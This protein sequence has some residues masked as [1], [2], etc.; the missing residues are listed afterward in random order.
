MDRGPGGGRVSRPVII[1]PS[2]LAAD[3]G[4]LAEQVREATAGGADRFHLDVMDGH[5][6]P[7]FTMGP[8]VVE[9]IRAVTTV[10]LEVHLMVERPELFIEAFIKSGADIV[11]VQVE[12][13][14]QLYRTVHRIVEL[15][16]QAAVALNP[17]TPV[18]ALREI[19]PYVSEIN[20]M[21]VEPGFGG[22]PFIT[23]SPA[24]IARV[25]ALAPEVD[26]QVDGGVDVR[27]APLAVAAGAN[28]LVAGTSV[29]RF[30][31]G[32]AAGIDSIRA[33]L[34]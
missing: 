8:A 13:T 23:T 33:A 28:V 9:A 11:E 7:N 21:T 19:V 12:T 10:P 20:V 24:K 32:V 34:V 2:I 16:A 22:Q 15:G 30:K 14:Y 31:G 3:F 6:V 18:E 29:F 25:R 5:F 1:A 27:T 26:I 17:S 4:R